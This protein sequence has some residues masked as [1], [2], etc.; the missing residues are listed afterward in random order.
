MI[1]LI[2]GEVVEK[3]D[4]FLILQVGGIGLKIWTTNSISADFEKGEI[5]NLF[6]DLILRENDVNL[7]GFHDAKMRDLFR[8]FI[9]V[10]GVGPKAALSI[11]SSLSIQN[12]YQAV[13]NKDFQPF[14]LAP[15]VG[16]KTAQKI[17]LYLQDKLDPSMIGLQSDNIEDLDTDLL[18]ALVSLGYSVVEAQTCIQSL[19]KDAPKILEEK[20][21]LALNY[22]S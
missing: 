22:F 17:I 6:T 1:E 7:Y 20:L 10:N 2:K 5:A 9:T 21:R 18:D 12:I 8:I 14:L 4:S 3:G 11:L 13:H 15:G 19:P 16:N